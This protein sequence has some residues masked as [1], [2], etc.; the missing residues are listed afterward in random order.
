MILFAIIDLC[1]E[2]ER[3]PMT[4]IPHSFGTHDGTFHADEV[5]A[6]ALLIVFNLVDRTAIYRTRRPEILENCEFVCD[7]GG[8]YNPQTK[9]FDHHQSTYTGDMSS[10]G[11]VLRYLKDIALLDNEEYDFINRSLIIGVDA[12]DN[13]KASQLKGYCTFSNIVSNFTP[14]PYDASPEMQTQAFM[15]AVDFAVGHLKR[16]RER[17]H[18]VRS[19]R[20]IVSER[21]QA[22]KECL[23]FDEGLPWLESFFELG[24]EK[25]P[26]LFVIM[27]SGPHWKLRGVPPSFE[28]RMSVRMPLPAAWAGL[29]DEDL[30]RVS[31]IPGA[32]FCHKERF[33]SVWK[34]REDALEALKHVLHSPKPSKGGA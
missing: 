29:L 23:I 9:H 15:E 28:E 26:A 22:C 16:L 13:G 27:P 11:M 6:C 14:I 10:A 34:T 1:P 5:T 17:Y 20:E 3:Q 4:V 18:Y 8:V 25:H 19:C 31:G 21:M 30:Q 12:H 7:V 33:I 24:G 2:T 32:V